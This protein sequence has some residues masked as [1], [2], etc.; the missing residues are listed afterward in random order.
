MGAWGEGPFENDDAG[1]WAYQFDGLDGATGLQVLA[2]ALA[3]VEADEYLEAPE[4]T[5]A[6]A[7]AA[8]VSWIHDPKAIPESP[9]SDAA[10]TWV[11]RARPTPSASLVAAAL[12]ALNRVRTGE[13]ELAELWAEGEDAAW[14]ESL[15]QIETRLQARG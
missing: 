1:D 9:Y 10:A 4:A 3:L 5:A 13:S 6:V 15:T 2:D 12:S 11:R 8:V 7:A 14:R